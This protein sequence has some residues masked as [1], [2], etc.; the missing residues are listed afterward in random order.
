MNINDLAKLAER[1]QHESEQSLMAML[2]NLRDI[3]PEIADIALRVFN[4]R[5]KAIHWLASPVRSLGDIA[6]LQALAE[7]KRE[8]VLRVLHQIM[9]GVYG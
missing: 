9:H 2:D 8:D 4:D 5:A 7:G 1:Y 3:D 6:P